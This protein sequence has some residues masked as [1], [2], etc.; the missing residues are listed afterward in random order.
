MTA[1]PQPS[2]GRDRMIG[3]PDTP[4]KPASSAARAEPRET[5]LR[6]KSSSRDAR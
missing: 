4:E 1:R 3:E 5:V 2:L 6:E